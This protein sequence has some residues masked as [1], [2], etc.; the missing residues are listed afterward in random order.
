MVF[1]P[2]QVDVTLGM[3]FETTC[4]VSGKGNVSRV[5][6][7]FYGWVH[8]TLRLSPLAVEHSV[9]VMTGGSQSIQSQIEFD[10]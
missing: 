7:T 3:K 10:N 5:I 8:E 1:D 6:S 2:L 4:T 9:V